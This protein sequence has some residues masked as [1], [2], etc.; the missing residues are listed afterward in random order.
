[1]RFNIMYKKVGTYLATCILL[2]FFCVHKYL[3]FIF[4]DALKYE[5]P[6]LLE[7][8]SFKENEKICNS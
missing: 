6:S 7:I 4:S 3:D 1:M 5:C 2:W 8:L